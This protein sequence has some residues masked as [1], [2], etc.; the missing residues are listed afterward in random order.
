[1]APFKSS[2]SEPAAGQ[3]TTISGKL[4]SSFAGSTSFAGEMATEKNFGVSGSLTVENRTFSANAITIN[5]PSGHPYGR[6]SSSSGAE[7]GGPV[8]IGGTASSLGVSGSLVI[9]NRNFDG[10]SIKLSNPDGGVYGQ[11]SSSGGAKFSSDVVVGTN[12]S[13][14]VSGSIHTGW[15]NFNVAGTTM[16]ANAY[17]CLIL[18]TGGSTPQSA[19]S[20][21]VYMTAVNSS[22]AGSK[23]TLAVD[24]EE[25]V[26][27]DTNI[28]QSA[29]AATHKLKIYINGTEYY[30]ALKAV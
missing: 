28:M 23:A 25:Q 15:G 24:L 13:L 12:S 7:F 26:I 22:T 10:Y 3:S 6:L 18:N 9:E 27:A 14:W 2:T 8:A 5:N 30:I 4:S 17:S 16:D 11:L 1:M 20:N 21:Q 19:V 29:D